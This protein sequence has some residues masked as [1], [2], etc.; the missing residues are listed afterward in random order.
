MS[1]LHS[2]SEIET[3]IDKRVFEQLFDDYYNELYR[4]IFY[5]CGQQDL[6]NDIVQ[7]TFVKVW[8]LKDKIRIKTARALMYKMAGNLM[9]NNIKRHKTVIKF[10]QTIFDDR[11]FES[12]EFEMELKEFDHKLQNVLSKL[13]E[14]SRV[15]FLMSRIDQMT[16]P[17]I[18]NNLGISVKAV[19]KRMKK[20]LEYLRIKIEQKI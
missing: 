9:I 18:A 11:T 17:E 20:A 19:E 14:K 13:N 6:A 10:Q 7:D 3:G 4:Y 2:N 12:P 16:Y 15:V 1:I 5:K 8:E